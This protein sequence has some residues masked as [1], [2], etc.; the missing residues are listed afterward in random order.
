MSNRLGS[1]SL[2]VYRDWRNVCPCSIKSFSKGSNAFSEWCLK[3]EAPDGWQFEDGPWIRSPRG[4]TFYPEWH[5]GLLDVSFT[6]CSLLWREV[7]SRHWDPLTSLTAHHESASNGVSFVGGAIIR[8]VFDH[9]REFEGCN[10]QMQTWVG[11]CAH[12]CLLHH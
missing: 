7:V 10:S 9:L 6:S 11:C 12:R 1:Y 4:L 2:L 3:K 8:C 5:T